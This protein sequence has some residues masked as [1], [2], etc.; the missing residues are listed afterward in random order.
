MRM[1]GNKGFTMTELMVVTLVTGI[2]VAASIPSFSR[3]RESTAMNSAAEQIAGHFRLMR[4]TAVAEGTPYIIAFTGADTY[5]TIED[6]NGDGLFTNGESYGGPYFLPGTTQISSFVGFSSSWIN[7][8][9]N[10]TSSEGG[11]IDLVNDRGQVFR[12]TL[13]SSTGHVQIIK[14]VPGA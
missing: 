12:I 13:L 11:S 9:P 10:G 2:A 7:M 5:F 8:N 4:Q 1:F 6:T 14:D 3:F